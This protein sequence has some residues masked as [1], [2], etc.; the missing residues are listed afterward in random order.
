[1]NVS[2]IIAAGGSSQR[3]LKGRQSREKFS[4]LFLS[5]GEKPL[6]RHTLESFYGIPKIREIVLAV[7]AGTEGWIKTHV[8]NSHG[9][10]SVRIVRGGKTRAESVWKALSKTSQT[11]DWVLVHD[12]ARPFP[13]R[14]EIKEMLRKPPKEDGVIL[15]R[16]V[17]PTLKRA[18]PQG[19]ILG[20]VDRSNLFEA[21]TPQLVRRSVLIKAY[22]QNPEA[23]K[24]TD[25]SSL[26][27]AI[28][29]RMKVK[30]HTDWNVKVTT[31][32]DL[33]IARVHLKRG[34]TP[35]RSLTPFCIGLG[36]DTHRL[37]E[38]R[39][40]YLGGV[41]IPFTKG[42]F[43]HSDGDALLHAVSDAILGSVSS[44]DIG[45]WFSDR[46]KKFKNIRSTKILQT[47]L[48][49][50]SQKGWEPAQVDSVITLEKPQLGGLKKKIGKN[51]AK[52]L[53]LPV[54]SVSVKAKTAEGLGPEGEGL[55]VTCE[56]IVLMRKVAP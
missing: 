8:L 52:L 53:N 35:F 41:W 43:G 11:N 47:V 56:A 12:G 46:K 29:G 7:P 3:F 9:G 6:L 26:V 37:I 34:Q 48:S 42:A 32:R 10:A 4:K 49:E 21:E 44:G 38:G 55:A 23:L 16:A 33:D 2:L 50:A 31:P 18:N 27:E 17:V 51:L 30:V 15:A 14:D 13:P 1:M 5:L 25:E 40:F 20:T 45:E 24:A 22:R 54:D 39:K 28:G 19:K 36:R